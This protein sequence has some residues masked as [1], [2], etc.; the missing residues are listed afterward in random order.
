[1]PPLRR[2]D[3]DAAQANAWRGT[4]CHT[5]GV[6]EE[7]TPLPWPTKGLIAAFAASGVVHLVRPQVF[8]PLIPAA[9]P[10]PRALVYGS[11]VAELACAAGLATRRPWAPAASAALLLAVWPANW[12]M[13]AKWQQSAD[14][15]PLAKA[16]GWAR[17]P[18]QIP[19]IVAAWRSP[20][21]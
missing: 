5:R 6:T 11:G 18:V 10:A 8:E 15:P 14:V 12:T 9:L 2:F 20:R 3:R 7:P 13:A 16:A 17:L 21:R 19:L 1:M 4:R